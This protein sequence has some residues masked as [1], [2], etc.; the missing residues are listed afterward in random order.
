MTCCTVPLARETI[1]KKNEESAEVFLTQHF[2]FMRSLGPALC[3]H[4]PV[5]AFHAVPLHDVQCS[6]SVLLPGCLYLIS[7]INRQLVQTSS[8][9]GSKQGSDNIA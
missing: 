2:W 6:L 7:D 4:L 3:S 9:R 1:L 8:K 5:E